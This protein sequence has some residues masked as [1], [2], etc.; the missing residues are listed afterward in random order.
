MYRRF[1][2]AHEFSFSL[3]E[4]W[5]VQRYSTIKAFITIVSV[6]NNFYV[7]TKTL[8]VD[9]RQIRFLTLAA[10]TSHVTKST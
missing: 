4:I 1:A 5:R 10:Q 2:R 3:L 9:V 6:F 7:L 8:I